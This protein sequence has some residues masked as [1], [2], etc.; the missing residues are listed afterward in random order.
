MFD[1][2]G[3]AEIVRISDLV[4]LDQCMVGERTRK[5]TMLLHDGIDLNQLRLPQEEKSCIGH[6]T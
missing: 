6:V 1:M 5:P 3:F 4:D 2:P